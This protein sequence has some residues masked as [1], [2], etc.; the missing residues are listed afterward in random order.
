MT[1]SIKDRIKGDL[2]YP[3]DNVTLIIYNFLCDENNGKMHK[4]G[5]ILDLHTGEIKFPMSK[6]NQ[7]DLFW[8]GTDIRGGTNNIEGTNIYWKIKEEMFVF[9]LR[10]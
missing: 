1:I 9:W 5:W 7:T 4:E 3:P 8:F 2:P 10:E 6:L